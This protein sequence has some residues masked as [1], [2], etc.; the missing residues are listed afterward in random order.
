[1][2]VLSHQPMLRQVMLGVLCALSLLTARAVHADDVNAVTNTNPIVV[3]DNG[4]PGAT[5][6]LIST[7]IA[8]PA[9]TSRELVIH[10]FAECAVGGAAAGSTRFIDYDI[11]VDGVL[12]PPTDVA[13]NALCQATVDDESVGTVVSRTVSGGNHT[14]RVQGRMRGPAPGQGVVDDQSLVVEEEAP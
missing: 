6:T 14:I 2:Y 3:P 8:T 12:V 10:Y 4:N 5:V 7:V 11:L 1:M 9:N 13:D